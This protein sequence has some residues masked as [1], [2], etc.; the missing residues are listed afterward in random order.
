MYTGSIYSI[1]MFLS[2]IFQV[3]V[4]ILLRRQFCAPHIAELHISHSKVEQPL[5]YFNNF[6]KLLNPDPEQR[7]QKLIKTI[8]LQ[9]VTWCTDSKVCSF[10]I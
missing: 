3:F 9:L 1:V 10:S 7:Y 2:Y 8:L 6:N 4:I 5:N